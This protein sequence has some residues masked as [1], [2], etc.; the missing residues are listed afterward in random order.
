[1]SEQATATDVLAMTAA[2][3]GAAAT[4]GHDTGHF[5]AVLTV[6]LRKS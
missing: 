6:G 2:L 4:G 3:Y 1:M 5:V